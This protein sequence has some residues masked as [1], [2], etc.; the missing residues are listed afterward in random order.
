MFIMLHL[1]FVDLRGLHEDRRGRAPRPDWRSDDPGQAFVRDFG[2]MVTRNAKAY[3]LVGERAYVEFDRALAFPAPGSHRQ[4]GW[5]HGVPLR[6]WFRRLYFDG[7]IAG[8]FEIGFNTDATAETPILTGQWPAYDVGE[9]ARSVC[10]IPVEV[11]SSDGS[12]TASS[13]ERC[14][15][16]LGLAYLVATTLHSERE[17]HPAHELV[18]SVFKVGSPAIHI[19]APH[20]SRLT[21]PGDRRNVAQDED[22]SRM[23]LTSVAKAQRRSTL[24]VQVS[25]DAGGETPGERARRVLFTHLNAVLHA[26]DFLTATMDAKTIER[27]RLELKDLTARALER[28]GRLAITAPRTD[29]DEAFAQALRVFADEHAGRVDGIVAKLDAL[30]RDAAAPKRMER[31]AGWTRGW[32]EFF[33]DSAIKAS[34]KALMAAK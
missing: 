25:A 16:A 33:A 29:G 5:S 12:V 1:P 18:G 30:A 9:L 31:I 23:F 22:G 19:R 21:L 4:E 15:S 3:G 11:R 20:G 13:L 24:T 6:V 32:T 8:R 10:D 27:H 26:N 28:F 7:D 34:V 14:G 2:G 17:N